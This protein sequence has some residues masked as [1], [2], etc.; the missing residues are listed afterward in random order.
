MK[1]YI[2]YI[3]TL[4]AALALPAAAQTGSTDTKAA[5]DKPAMPYKLTVSTIGSK[6]GTMTVEDS[7]TGGNG[8]TSVGN[9]TLVYGS[10]GTN[11]TTVKLTVTPATGYLVRKDYPKAYKTGESAT[12]VT[13]TGNSSP[14]TFAMPAYPVTI[15]IAYAAQLQAIG[16][17]TLKESKTTADDVK[18]ILPAYIP[19]TLASGRKDSLKVANNGWSY[20][21]AD[22]NGQSNAHDN[23]S[24]GG[25]YNADPGAVN[26]F[27]F[28]LAAALHDSIT[29]NSQTPLL[30]GL[31][32]KIKVA[33]M[34]EPLKPTDANKGITITGGTGSNLNGQ[35]GDTGDAKPFNGTI[36]SNDGSTTTIKAI[37]VSNDVKDA[38]LTL[39]NVSVTGGNNTTD[40]K[41]VIKDGANVTIKLEGNNT[42]SSLK[43]E[44]SASLILQPEAGAT[45]TNTTIEN[46]GTFID[47]TA[48]VAKVTGT[49]ALDIKA[50]VDGG[51]SVEQGKTATLTASTNDKVGTTFFT[52][53]KK[54]SDGSYT[55]VQ[56]NEYDKDGA[57]ITKAAGTGITDSYKPATSATGSSDYRCL[58]RREVT[59]GGATPSTAI[60]LLSTKSETVTVT[61]KSDPGD[62]PGSDDNDPSP[63]VYYTV[64]LPQLTGATTDPVAGTHKVESWGTFS[65]SLTLAKDYDLSKPVVTTD[66][67]ETITPRTSDGKYIITYVRSDLSINITGI[68]KNNP[69]ANEEIAAP[70]TRVW[71]SRGMLHVS[72]PTAAE[73]AIYTFGGVR[74][75]SAMLPA[76]DTQIALPAGSYVVVA[77]NESSFKII[78]K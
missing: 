6:N 32:G 1:A 27:S 57:L 67:G 41:T 78:I 8:V 69:T 48:T 25:A 39:N 28:T 59:I 42:L 26:V 2:I 77:G 46:A 15:E 47:S 35:T 49:G 38:T 74:L 21:T 66:R 58:V 65:F 54:N 45:L 34:A 4:L 36:G 68:V 19:V 17:I 62:N 3:A 13:L 10:T 24:T 23:K 55:D 63:T 44:G 43:V 9:D 53:Q 33:N 20:N 18:S 51:G 16:A 37:E 29:D 40:N 5:P 64:T 31:T 30:S 56:T 71:G 14:Y 75:K 22:N 76:G 60:T 52:W 73:V 61:P 72:Q 11:A 12:A 7:K 50:D 70:G